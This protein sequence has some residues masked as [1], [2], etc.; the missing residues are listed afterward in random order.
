MVSKWKPKKFIKITS[1]KLD[2]YTLHYNIKNDSDL[3]KKVDGNF[4][5]T[6]TEGGCVGI[7]SETCY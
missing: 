7:V 3:V 2:L 4:E 1:A 6:T 5:S